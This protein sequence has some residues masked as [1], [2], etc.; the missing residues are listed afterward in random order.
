M[1]F[2]GIIFDFNGVLW[3][4]SHLQEAAWNQFAAQVR[5]RPFSAAEIDVH[6]HGRNNQHSFSYLVDRPITGEE[7]AA[8]TQQ[9]ESIY[10][11]LC[12]DQG[13]D[14]KL[15]PGAI[16]LLDY[17][18]DHRILHT[19]ATASEK[20]N[21]DFF[22]QHLQLNRWFALENIIYDDGSRPGKP[23]PDYYLAAAA[24]LGLDPAHCIVV[25][26]SRSGIAAAHAAGMGH[27]VA[28]GPADT[29]PQLQQLS[30]VDRVITHLGDL[31][32]ELLATAV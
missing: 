12:L 25:E 13:V 14:F 3:W 15:S 23:A 2:K 19:I 4:D 30:G 11:Q 6:V 7:L 26:D 32:Q 8:L 10:R 21:L 18:V 28:L 22:V 31:P 20:T 1:T 5:G 27:V 9:K 16:D 24:R 29:H 17:L